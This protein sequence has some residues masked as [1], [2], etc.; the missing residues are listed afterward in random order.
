MFPD[1]IPSALNNLVND[2]GAYTIR[3]ALIYEIHGTSCK[4]CSVTNN[5]Q[6]FEMR[7]YMRDFTVRYHVFFVV[8]FSDFYMSGLRI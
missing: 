4:I 7:L 1:I 2:W 6:V 5:V 8:A 3:D